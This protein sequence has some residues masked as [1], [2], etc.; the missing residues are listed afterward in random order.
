MN[1]PA[2][3][4]LSSTV[5]SPYVGL[6]HY[7]EQDAA[8]FFGR[9][10]LR[11]I[12]IG[13]LRAARLTLLYAESGVGK[14]SLLRAGVAARLLALAERDAD[15]RGSPRLVPVVFSAWSEQ[16]GAALIDAIG[17]AIRPFL[18]E[19]ST[20]ELP[21]DRLDEAIEVAAEALDATLLVI[22]DQFEEHLLY[23]REG[24]GAES[25]ADQLAR[26]VNRP[27]LR[28][29]FLI[30]IREDAY[31]GL[32]DLFR[33][34]IANVYGNYLH[35]EYL[36]RAEA[37]DAIVK[38]IDRTN[39]L[40]PGAEPFEIQVE[41]V[42]AVLDQVRRGQFAAGEDGHG[43]SDAR[44]TGEEA[45]QIETT[46]LQLVM[47][48]LWDEET[49]AGSRVLRLETLERLGGAQTIIGTHLDRSMAALAPEQQ[50]AAAS[51]FRFLVTSAGTK[52]A[53]TA[54]DLSE[55]S[56]TQESEVDPVLRRLSAGD[57]HIL[58]PI[59][60][61]D[62]LGVP[63]YEIFHD[64]L[65]RPILDWRA[66]QTRVELER[67]REEKERA[68]RDATTERRRK[69]FAV[70]GLVVC[71]VALL[72]TAI[73]LAVVQSNLAGDRE[74]TA[75]SVQAAERIF[76]LSGSPTFGPSAAALAGIETHELWPTFEARNQTLASLQLNAGLPKIG[77]GHTRAVQAVAYWPGSAKLAS[78][79]LDG[80]I[81]LW[82]SRG[83]QLG[84]PLVIPNRSE[85]VLGVAVSP[86]LEGGRR[87]LAAAR[88]DEGARSYGGVDLWDLTEG[89]FVRDNG[90]TSGI[91]GDVH[92]VAFNPEK[93]SMLVTGGEDGRIRIWDVADP[94]HP[95]EVASRSA[96]GPVRGL[97]FA[98]SGALASAGRGG[99]RLWKISGFGFATGKPRL[100]SSTPATS[101]ATAPNGS[102]AFGIR[103]GID[104]W[105]SQR[106]HVFLP[107]AA[108]VTSLA[109]A[110]RGSTLV[111]GSL[112]WNV[113]TWDVKSGRPFGPPRT[114]NQE[115]VNGIAIRGDG[116]VIVSAGADGFV[117]L[118]PL[119]PEGALATTVGGLSPPEAVDRTATIAD[120]A[121]GAAGRVAAA[122]RDAGALVWGLDRADD[123]T[124]RPQPLVRIPASGRRPTYAVAYRGDTLAAARGESFTVW[125]TG[126]SCPRMPDDACR[127]GS[128][129]RPHGSG[130][131]ST[132]AFAQNDDSQ[133]LGSGS[134]NGF[135]NLWEVTQAG[136]VAHVW[137]A[138]PVNDEIN[139]VA[140]SPTS[141]LVAVATGD[142]EIR[143]WNAS[144]P[145]HPSRVA[146]FSGHERQ[147][148]TSLAF[149]PDGELLASGG[150]DQQVVFWEV[151]WDSA[152]DEATVSRL[153]ST[154]YQTETIFALAFSLDG[155]TL[156]AGDG[157]GAAC[158]Y[159]VESSRLIGGAACLPGHHTAFA[160]SGGGINAALFAADG[161]RLLTA[162]N[163]NPIVAW[164]SILWD[165][166][167]DDQADDSIRDAVCALAGRNL[168]EDEWEAIF[169][170]T[171]LAGDRHKTCPQYPLP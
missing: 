104:L 138:P 15:T 107:T 99:E 6:T 93:P 25:F 127:L 165:Q 136:K 112:D 113:T 89:G 31:A 168:T 79:G 36:D 27:D 4:T 129:I 95:R 137:E 145:R 28:A 5:D 83:R 135:L 128:P 90:L 158:V 69:R 46:Y 157:D 148:V 56:G 34:R 169:T 82:N 159:E 47:K 161:T 85:S 144:D 121:L 72:A 96:G 171:E 92:A 21:P 3:P 97:A 73:V 162:G 10:A 2:S 14:S 123:S 140:F 134:A 103:N 117:K 29:N 44:P 20:R 146:A 87:T 124:R 153:P 120:L 167:D 12:I 166:G 100:V 114:H 102:Y 55:L 164:S 38:P 23:R 147:P 17:E 45:D 68:Q 160:A 53:L 30:S 84:D 61:R 52:I 132:L 142:G 81:R 35:L 139:E 49:G 24:E 149:S 59:A 122:A 67:V 50:S 105:D 130:F 152:G 7:T 66:R 26:C 125:D 9:D 88:S 110:D 18:P 118:W 101:V 163:S 19:E 154:L 151:L 111:S 60:A 170:G 58:R 155:K 74:K 98:A 86:P 13:N 76:S 131:I 37:R 75:Q 62:G 51:I 106:R 42:D 119:R 40:H 8:L 41:L 54:R 133:L 156:A 39:E 141:P 78:G 80:T 48:R 91:R 94:V 108:E 16:P 64:A 150:Q 11:G 63:S 126:S 70:A 57:L 143:I 33:G 65:A 116:R 1:R 32:G 43:P 77:V 22:L 71:G 109:F 115:A